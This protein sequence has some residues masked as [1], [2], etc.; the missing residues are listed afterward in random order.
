MI[1]GE[2][3][4]KKTMKICLNHGVE[5]DCLNNEQVQASNEEPS[6]EHLDELL[7]EEESYEDL[8]DINTPDDD[9]FEHNHAEENIIGMK[10]KTQR[11]CF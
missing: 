7:D 8:S 10:I 1:S 3:D 5:E 6:I 2:Q 9:T 4:L 11:R